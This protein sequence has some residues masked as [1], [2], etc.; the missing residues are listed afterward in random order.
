MTVDMKTKDQ[1]SGCS[2]CVN[3][4]PKHCISMLP[5]NEGFIY[6]VID[7]EKCVH[8][9]LCIKDCSALA[10]KFDEN[11][12]P[13]ID[14]NRCF[15]CQH[16]LA[17]CPTGALSICNKHPENSDSIVEHDS[18]NILNLIKSRRSIRHYKQQ[19][20]DLEKIQKLLQLCR[21]ESLMF[22][23]IAKEPRALMQDFILCL[24]RLMSVCLRSVFPNLR[25]FIMK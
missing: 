16:C 10:L 12:I 22:L 21:G 15:K 24:L 7:K 5:D 4:C 9:G 25:I 19:N 11:K 23:L 14:E 17:V 8:C 3:I 18:E 13:Q 6:P 1:C 20:V 2:A